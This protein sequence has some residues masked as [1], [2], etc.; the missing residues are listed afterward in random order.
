MGSKK[1][2][3]N[4]VA[5]WHFRVRVSLRERGS[6]RRQFPEAGPAQYVARWT[7]LRN[8]TCSKIADV[9]RA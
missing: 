7:L 8:V 5:L 6:Q 4:R 1:A 2:D 9:I 3:H